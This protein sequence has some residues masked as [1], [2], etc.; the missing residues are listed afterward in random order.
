MHTYPIFLVTENETEQIFNITFQVVSCQ[1]ASFI[2]FSHSTF[3]SNFD[4]MQRIQYDIVL[5][6]NITETAESLCVSS[7]VS[8]L[9]Q[10]YIAET[11]IVIV[12]PAGTFPYHM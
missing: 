3:S 5:F 9:G 7:F 10:H 11:S 2:N 12:D 1:Q 6:S 4:E 8:A